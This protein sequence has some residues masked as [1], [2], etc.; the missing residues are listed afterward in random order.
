MGAKL[1]PD[2]GAADLSAFDTNGDGRLD[3]AERKQATTLIRERHDAMRSQRK[4]L[5]EQFDVDGDGSLSLDE[6][7]ALREQLLEQGLVPKGPRGHR[8]NDRRGRGNRRGEGHSPNGG[9]PPGG[10][11]PPNAPF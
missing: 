11:P 10:P 4:A 5:A 6:R 9:P 7:K 8:P 3:D 2:H 1:H